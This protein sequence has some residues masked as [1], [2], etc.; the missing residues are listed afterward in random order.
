MRR[1]LK[2]LA[3][4]L[5]VAGALPVAAQVPTADQLELLRSM[6]PEDREALLEQLGLGGSVLGEGDADAEPPMR[7]GSRRDERDAMSRT[8]RDDLTL[9]ELERAESKLNP[10]DSLLIDLDF[11]RDKPPRIEN[12]GAGLPPVTIP[13]ELAPVLEPTERIEL[14][15]RIDLVRSR[16]PYQLDRS[17][18]LVL[19]G[20]APIMLAGLDAEQA[21]HRL[22]VVGAFQKLDVKVTKLTV[23]KTGVRGSQ[24]LRI[25]TV[26]GCLVHVRAGDGHPGAV[27]LHCR[28]RRSTRCAVVR[29]P[30]SHVCD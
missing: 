24:A 22:A 14:Q 4:I 10:E 3:A 19:P 21:T 13:G 15:A 1:G 7:T 5:L 11:K 12:Q 9:Q 28:A 26:Q 8:G 2:V 30:E 27:G 23:R 18:V 25:R 29:Q 17:G 6:S 20:F 16:N